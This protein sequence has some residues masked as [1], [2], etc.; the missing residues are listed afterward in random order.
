MQAEGVKTAIEAHRRAKP[1]CMGSLYWQLNDCWPVT[2]WSSVDYYGDKKASNY[3]V[4]RS[5]NDLIVSVDDKNDSLYVYVISDK[6]KPVTGLLNIELID[7]KGKASM[8]QNFKIEV[9]ANSS[10]VC[11]KF[12]INDITN[13]STS[14][15]SRIFNVSFKYDNEI[16]SA[17]Y[18][19][20]KPKDL[21]LE[22]PDIK[23]SPLVDG[24]FEITSNTLAKDVCLS[25]SNDIIFSDN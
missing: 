6:L 23:I 14:L 18:Y 10:V 9:P 5:F 21:L 22:K 15:G 13:E 19:F 1:Y 16:Q 20:V 3:Q 12:G 2:S 24:Y 17:D 11:C 25:S 4:K 8:F 7:F